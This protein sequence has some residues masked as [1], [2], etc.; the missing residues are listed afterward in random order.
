[1]S[2]VDVMVVDGLTAIDTKETE[3]GSAPS[4]PAALTALRR[5]GVS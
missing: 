3:E 1:M 5:G 2:A 4:S